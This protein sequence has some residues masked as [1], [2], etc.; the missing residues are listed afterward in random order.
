MKRAEDFPENHPIKR[1]FRTFT[2]RG[3]AQASVRDPDLLFYLAN[4]LVEFLWMENLHGMRDADGRRLESL[5]DMLAQANDA[6]LREKTERYKHLGDYSLFML[7]MFPEY[8]ARSRR[9]LSP[10]WYQDTGRI[11]Y[12]IAGEL[13]KNVWRIQV[14]RKLEDKFD[15]CVLSLNWV[16]EYSTDPFYQWMFREFGIS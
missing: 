10:S 15:R 1:I 16:R 9:A 2:E 5:I 7:G 4:L 8:I 6:D 12:H 14:Y 13:D 3:L 11:G